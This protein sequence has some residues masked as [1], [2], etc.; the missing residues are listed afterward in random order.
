MTSTTSLPVVEALQL[1]MSFV[2]ISDLTYDQKGR[3]CKALPKALD[4][5]YDMSMRVELS[6]I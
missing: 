3:D 1:Q 6:W 2:C 5:Y 4:A